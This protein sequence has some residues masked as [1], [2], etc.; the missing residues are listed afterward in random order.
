MK[1]SHGR[2]RLARQ[3]RVVQWVLPLVL[4]LV[5]SGFEVAE[6]ILGSIRGITLSFAGEVLVFGIA[7]PLVVW[8]VLGWAGRNQA[9]LERA[10]DDFRRLNRELEQRVTERT[11]ELADRNEALGKANAELKAL[12][13]L[14]SEFVSLVSHELRGPLTNV[15]GG[16]ELLMRE[17][18]ALSPA[19]REALDV[20]RG[21][22]TRLTKLVQSIL[23]VSLLEAGRLTPAPRP[24]PLRPFLGQLLKGRLPPA[25]DHRLVMDVPVDLPPAWADEAH[26]ADVIVNLVDNAVKYS[27]EGGEIRVSGHRD[28]GHE[29]VLSVSDQGIGIAPEEQA[30][31]FGRF[32]RADSAA[33]REVYGHGLGLYFCRKLVEAQQ[34]RIW[35]ESEGVPGRGATFH[36]GLPRCPEGWRDE[37]DPTD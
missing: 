33:D 30:R 4:F 26:L 32:Y 16:I 23:D 3:L 25:G 11:A 35:V 7:G 29:V 36:V 28:D 21:E 1:Q 34:G 6:H 24:L 31:L 15:N 10:N 8:W 5:A 2:P 12:D 27:P 18:H 22:C 17:R 14:K 37:P 19:R 20:L 9:R 13:S